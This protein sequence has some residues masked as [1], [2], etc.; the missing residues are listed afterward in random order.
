[1]RG[2][3]AAE[4]MLTIQAPTWEVNPT[5]PAH[6]FEKHYVKDAAVFFTEYGG[7][8]TDRTRGWIE[9]NRDLLA[10]VDSSLRPKA[11][12]APRVPHF[13]GVDIAL[14]NDYSALAIGHNDEQGNVVLDRIDRI[15]AGEGL[16]KDKERLDFDDVARWIYDWSRQFFISKGIFDQ[17]AGIPLEQALA[18]K[19]LK[20]LEAVH[21]TRALT[22][23]I[24]QNFKDMML[25]QRVSLYDWPIPDGAEH[26]A[27]I[28]EL[29]ELQ[30]EMVSKYVILVEAPQVDG[31][32]DDYS[33]ALVRMVWLATNNISK[34]RVFGQGRGARNRSQRGTMVSPSVIAGN[35]KKAL[36]GGSHPSRQP[37]TM[38][39]LGGRSLKRW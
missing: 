34:P 33:D 15:C 18:K 4:N 31:K 32:H 14:V 11:K 38:R 20:Q 19:G 3:R 36:L 29:L 13:M 17:W 12:A 9:D 39:R 16:Y 23:Q 7:E 35:K 22:S 6:E 21:H 24:Y 10:C 27:Y 1:M 37:K 28:E 5:I 2:G 30:A 26:C 25:D 8:F